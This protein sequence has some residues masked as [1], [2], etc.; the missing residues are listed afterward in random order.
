[1][2]ESTT[3]PTARTTGIVEGSRAADDLFETVLHGPDQGSGYLYAKDRRRCRSLG[4]WR[5]VRRGY[6]FDA[7]VLRAEQLDR[8]IKAGTASSVR[9][10]QWAGAKIYRK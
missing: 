7:R 6:L 3:D 10:S 2:S 9:N 4:V 5:R 1:M 8:G